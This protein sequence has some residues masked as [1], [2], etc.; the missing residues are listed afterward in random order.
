[1]FVTETVVRLQHTAAAGI[2]FFLRIYELAHS[3]YEE[4]LESIGHPIPQDMPNAPYI[5]PIVRSE[6][7]HRRP[8]RLGDRVR[9]Q[10]KLERLSSRA[11]TVHYEMTVVGSDLGARVRT[12]HVV[13]D[14]ET[15]RARQM[16]DD[17]R[18]ALLPLLAPS[19][20]A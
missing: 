18:A 6:A 12:T 20:D 3:T 16:P 15:G 9:I 11:F 13:A 10:A 8:F 4:L 1:M 14:P 7:D 19:D 5:I 2:M 17:L